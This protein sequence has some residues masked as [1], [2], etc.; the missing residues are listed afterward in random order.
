MSCVIPCL[1]NSFS[2]TYENIFEDLLV[3]D[4]S[5]KRVNTEMRIA[6]EPAPVL[7]HEPTLLPDTDSESESD[8]DM[9]SDTDTD[10]ETETDADTETDTEKYFGY[11]KMPTLLVLHYKHGKITP[12]SIASQ[13]KTKQ[14]ERL[15]CLT[16]DRVILNLFNLYKLI[17]FY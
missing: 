17:H 15:C 2:F 10:T 4:I 16:Q 6:P 13:S 11:S 8:T 5:R 1:Y 12:I 9:E 14:V 7:V 3:A